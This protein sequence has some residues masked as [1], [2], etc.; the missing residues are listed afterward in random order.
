MFEKKHQVTRKGKG[1]ENGQ[2]YKNSSSYWVF[3]SKVSWKRY[4]DGGKRHDERQQTR[5]KRYDDDD[6]ELVREIYST[7]GWWLLHYLRGDG[8]TQQ[9][10][11]LRLQTEWQRHSPSLFANHVRLDCVPKHHVSNNLLQRLIFVDELSSTLW[12]HTN[13]LSPSSKCIS[14]SRVSP[15]KCTVS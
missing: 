12:L 10:A 15:I 11:R 4:E 8:M 13:R 3:G 2:D 7:S 6:D 9:K 1:H 14:S 5:R